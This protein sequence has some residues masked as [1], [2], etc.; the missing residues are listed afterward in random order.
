MPAMAPFLFEATV[1]LSALV[2]PDAVRLADGSEARLFGLDDPGAAVALPGPQEVAGRW[3]AE[4][5]REWVPSPSGDGGGEMR[6]ALWLERDGRSL[7][8]EL[9]RRGV[10]LGAVQGGAG[11]HLDELLAATRA[12]R[13]AR[14]G[15]WGTVPEAAGELPAAGVVLALHSRDEGYAYS[16]ELDEIRALGAR[17]VSLVVDARIA[18]VDASWVPRRR[19]RAPSRQRV[20]QT[21]RAARERGLAVLLM[22]IVLIEDP[23]PDDWRGALR[24]RDRAVWWHS[25]GAWLADFA[26]L[27]RECGAGALSIGSELSSLE[28]DTQAWR[29]IAAN[30][31]LRFGGRLLYSANW[32]HFETIEFWDA[33]DLAGCSA[34]FELSDAIAPSPAELEAGWRRAAR[35][36]AELARRSGLPVLLTELGCPSRVGGAQTPWDHTR[37]GPVDLLVQERAFRAFHRVMVEGAAPLRGGV[38]LYEWWGLGG[39]ED[40]SYTARGKPAEAAWRAILSALAGR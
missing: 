31:R 29:R 38:F 16:R 22:P 6:E 10:A 5:L 20:A 7:N 12:A 11:A 14:A 24:P 32:D 25:Y 13:A 26:D 23:G 19:T 1:V 28:R 8:L 37:A 18:S 33:L 9:V 27:A 15:L 2:G 39:P 17:W 35:E 30:A 3:T 4:V 34:Y 40:R 36:L 21:I